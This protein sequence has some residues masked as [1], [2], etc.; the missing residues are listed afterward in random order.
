LRF[1]SHVV[2]IFL[3][4]GAIA[5]A[6][7]VTLETYGDS[8]TAGFLA[9]TLLTNPPPI[10]ELSKT[11]QNL[12]FAFLQKDR[13]LLKQFESNENAWPYFF[14]KNLAREGIVVSE[15]VNLA[16]SG[17][18]SSEIPRQVKQRGVSSAHTWALFF[19][20]HNDLCH[21]PGDSTVLT[22]QF[23]EHLN[24]AME[25]WEKNHE[26]SN[27]FLIPAAPIYEL[28]PVLDNYTWFE[29]EKKSFKCQ[30]AWTKY[31]PYCAHFFQ[32]YKKGELE[33]YLKPRT[34]AL[35]SSLEEIAKKW[36][37]KSSGKNTYRFLEA[38]WPSP[39]RPELFA[40][41]CYHIA[42]PGQQ[43]FAENILAAIQKLLKR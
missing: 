2:F 8:L 6:D 5:G 25:E 35:N 7:T 37:S 13:T 30:D 24:A 15:V 34:Q 14:A 22:Q 16:I 27:V 9:N 11:L 41:D 23:Q 31:F 17:S 21:V 26:G 19:V 42:A 33:S 28:Y 38:Q 18:R 1:L 29:S 39:L 3:V 36:D 20:G 32:R 43:I 40:M 4:S 10:S 12:A